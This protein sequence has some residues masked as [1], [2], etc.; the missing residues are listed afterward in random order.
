WRYARHRHFAGETAA[1]R[2]ML[3]EAL[4]LA[5]AV[6]DRWTV[7]HTLEYLG[8]CAYFLGDAD[9]AERC[10]EERLEAFQEIRSQSGIAR[11]RR[12]LAR[13]QLGRGDLD[14]ARDLLARSAALHRRVGS[15]TSMHWVLESFAGHAA[16]AGDPARS[17]RLAGAAAA[18]R[19]AQGN[20]MP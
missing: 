16:L 5:R 10:L 20:P 12:T 8:V 2:P 4:P 6:G 3:E 14:R 1:A 17:L 13:L 18:M 7:A 11:N 19:Q 15:I 9:E